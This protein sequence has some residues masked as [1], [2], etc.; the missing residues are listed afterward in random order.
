MRCQ[1]R[2]DPLVVSETHLNRRTA[3]P[4]TGDA[5]PR[6]SLRRDINVHNVSVGL[7]AVLW[8]TCGAVP[9]YLG[10][11]AP[12]GLSRE[13][14][15]SWFFIIFLTSG[16]SSLLLTLRFRQPIPI[17]WTFPGL[18]LIA[19]AGAGT[20]LAELTGASLV[21]GVTISIVG[22]LGL[23]TRLAR[24]LPLPLVLGMFAGSVLHFATDI[25]VNLDQQPAPVGAALVG[26]LVARS[27]NRPWLPPIAVAFF[28]G[29]VLAALTGQVH[30]TPLYWELPSLQLVQP[31][32]DPA[33]IIAYSLPLVVLIIGT[34]NTQGIGALL[35]QGYRPS[36]AALTSAV[37]ISSV[38]NALFG[39]HPAT[40]QSA[41]SAML[42]GPDA[43]P[44][45][46]RYVASLVAAVGC[47]ALALMATT[48]GAL[49]AILPAGLVASLAGLAMLRPLLDAL[50][51]TATTSLRMGSFFALAIAA[52][53][54]S[55]LGI[56]P[57]FWA[58][59]GGYVVSAVVERPALRGA[60]TLHRED[61]TG[62]ARAPAPSDHE[63]V[64]E[65]SRA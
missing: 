41:G 22:L 61:L 53:P 46:S 50:E 5:L 47:I 29:V 35:S 38:F 1:R 36:I 24:L 20:S 2:Q 16:V 51:R 27:L 30:A 64:A 49:I 9:F 54:F 10:T 8:Y 28:G 33:S 18:V 14:A 6:R 25:F 21:A 26:F 31:R 40:I 55:L 32:F 62:F 11:V 58:L 43:G 39:G 63:F 59:V 60:L 45:E 3:R 15:T 17:G 12:L 7:T 42:A 65:G 57:A 56:G 52:S 44:R 4:T 19:S 13:A 23:A 48:A 34:G 37:G